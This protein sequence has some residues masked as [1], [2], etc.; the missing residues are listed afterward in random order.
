MKIKRSILLPTLLGFFLLSTLFLLSNHEISIFGQDSTQN[1]TNSIYIPPTISKEAQQKLSTLQ[2]DLVSNNLPGPNDLNA[3]KKIF[4]ERE[5]AR[6]VNITAL[7]EFYQANLTYTKMGNANVIDIKP[8]NWSNGDKILVY[9]HGG[10]YT[11]LSANTTLGGALE[12]ANTTGLRMISVDYTLAPFSKWNQTTDQILSV[13][14][15]LRSNQGYPMDNLAMI[16]DSAGGD[17]TL[18]SVLKM[19]DTGIGL[20]GAVVVL[21]PNTDLTL[22]GDTVTTLRDADPILN[23]DAVKIMVSTYA[24]PNEYTIPYVSPIYGNFTEGFPP[25]LIQVGTKEILLSDSVRLYQALDQAHIP[26]KLDVY[27]G[28]PHV[29]QG[30]LANTPESKIA[31]SKINDFLKEY[32]IR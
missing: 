21:S 15:D 9:T 30:A 26:V 29:F 4:Q 24:N 7:S 20:P 23:A 8:N 11:Q 28:M 1:D 16:G 14:Q 18:G 5:S 12:I 22:T 3:W 27:E 2:P 6:D 25:T 31:I 17:M 13:I 32:L 10:G 19:R